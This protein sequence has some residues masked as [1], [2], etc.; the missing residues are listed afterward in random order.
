M[1][2]RREK[3]GFFTLFTPTPLQ[4]VRLRSRRFGFSRLLREENNNARPSALA[5][6]P[7]P[8]SG[9][10][11]TGVAA[12]HYKQNRRMLQCKS[13]VAT[14]YLILRLTADVSVVNSTI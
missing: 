9:F 4:L 13:D 2:E 12:L 8:V 1:N 6:R 14:L 3:R 10:K 11:R 7:V 5:D